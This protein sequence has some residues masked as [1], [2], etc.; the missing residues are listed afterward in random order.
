M[1][2][3]NAEFNNKGFYNYITDIIAVLFIVVLYCS[4]I[5]FMFE[6]SIL[7]IIT[8]ALGIIISIVALCIIT[9]KF[10]RK[11]KLSDI[12]TIEIKNNIIKICFENETC[13]EYNY[14]DIKQTN[15]C[16]EV[17][18]THRQFRAISYVSIGNIAISFL[19]NDGNLWKLNVFYDGIKK[20]LDTIKYILKELKNYNIN[21][22]YEGNGDASKIQQEINQ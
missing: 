5:L 6:V 4:A 11:K 3:K 1:I 15:I 18:V 22:K 17:N 12:K 7:A 8:I 16:I 21:L 10:K 9:N 2:I 13:I 19:F 20:S 14:N